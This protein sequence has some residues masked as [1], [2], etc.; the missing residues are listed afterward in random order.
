MSLKIGDKVEILPTATA[1]KYNSPRPGSPRWVYP[2][3]MDIGQTGVVLSIHPNGNVQVKVS[4]SEGVWMW[5]PEDL[6]GVKYSSA[7]SKWRRGECR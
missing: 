3:E 5:M 1:Q 7:T 2:M 4:T 6:R